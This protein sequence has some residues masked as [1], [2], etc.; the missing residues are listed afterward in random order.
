MFIS[1]SVKYYFIQL[2]YSKKQENISIPY[3][4]GVTLKKCIQKL[5]YMYNTVQ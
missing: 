4:T 1:K 5:I 3:G 2:N